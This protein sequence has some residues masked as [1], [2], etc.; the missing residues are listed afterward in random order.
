[1]KC[2]FCGLAPKLWFF[3]L[4][5]QGGE[6]ESGGAFPPKRSDKESS[7]RWSE[8]C[9]EERYSLCPALPIVCALGTSSQVYV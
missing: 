2:E 8:H 7:V 1:M 3:P 4:S 6:K 9:L 5:P